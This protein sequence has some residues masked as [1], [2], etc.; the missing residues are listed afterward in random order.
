MIKVL[1]SWPQ[2]HGVPYLNS[3]SA[4]PED[5][6]RFCQ[7]KHCEHD[8]HCLVSTHFFAFIRAVY[9]LFYLQKKQRHSQQRSLKNVAFPPKVTRSKIPRILRTDG[10]MRKLI[11]LFNS[12]GREQTLKHQGSARRFIFQVQ[13]RGVLSNRSHRPAWDLFP[14]LEKT[15]GQ[16]V[17]LDLHLLS[18]SFITEHTDEGILSD[19]PMT[20]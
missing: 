19:S 15:T 1:E 16:R 7:W 17:Q 18:T 9:L 4:A 12:T 14:G 13:N 20:N 3:K 8:P 5:I 11:C 2:C 6:K 10:T